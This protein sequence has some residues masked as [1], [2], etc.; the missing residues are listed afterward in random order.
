[1]RRR[2]ALQSEALQLQAAPA[3]PAG[4]ASQVLRTSLAQRL[5]SQAQISILGD[6][7]TV[8]LKAAPADG[9]AEWLRARLHVQRAELDLDDWDSA[10]MGSTAG[11]LWRMGRPL[12]AMLA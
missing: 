8:T 4:D 11:A 9:V 1:M 12:D 10:A 3:A 5:G 7:A 2:P 6:R